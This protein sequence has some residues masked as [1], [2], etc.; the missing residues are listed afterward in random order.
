MGRKGYPTGSATLSLIA[1]KMALDILKFFSSKTQSHSSSPDATV[2]PDVLR[3]MDV[4]LMI[5]AV[6]ASVNQP[7]FPRCPCYMVLASRGTISQLLLQHL[8]YGD[9]GHIFPTKI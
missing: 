3:V 2:L 4:F 1:L 5:S 7:V 9:R 8:L 6:T